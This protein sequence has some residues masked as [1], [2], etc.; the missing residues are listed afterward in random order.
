MTCALPGVKLSQ[1]INTGCWCAI[2]RAS[3]HSISSIYNDNE[4]GEQGQ[5]QNNYKDSPKYYI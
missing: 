3:F 5:L 4:Q 2:N 1:T